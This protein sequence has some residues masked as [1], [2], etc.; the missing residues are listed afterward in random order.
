MAAYHFYEFLNITAPPL[1]DLSVYDGNTQFVR[2]LDAG[3]V[4]VKNV[5][6]HA[7]LV[8]RL[9]RRLRTPSAS[10][11]LGVGQ[12]WPLEC[13]ADLLDIGLMAEAHDFAQHL[14]RTTAHG[15]TFP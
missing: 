7:P 13:L 12:A 14:N 10:R 5:R 2:K 15:V 6:A 1:L 8:L 4:V 11:T 3:L 9:G